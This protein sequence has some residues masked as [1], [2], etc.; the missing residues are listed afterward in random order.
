MA[1]ADVIDLTGASSGDEAPPPRAPKRARTAGGGG[2]AGAGG[3]DGGDDIMVTEAPQAPLRHTAAP[4]GARSAGGG[5]G[6]GD[7]SDEEVQI[8]GVA[9]EVRVVWAAG[10]LFVRK[11]KGR[12]CGGRSLPHAPSSCVALMRVRCV[13]LAGAAGGLCAPAARVRELSLRADAALA[14]V[15]MLSRHEHAGRR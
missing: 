14:V 2:G 4:A 7:S 5:G 1:D 9:G 10:T 6:G 15:R 8:T 3:A 12:C 11:T 13:F